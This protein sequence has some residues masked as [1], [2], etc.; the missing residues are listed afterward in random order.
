M[1]ASGAGRGARGAGSRP[2][3]SAP[4][5][6]CFDFFLTLGFVAASGFDEVAPRPQATT[7]ARHGELGANTPAKRVSANLEGGINAASR[8]RNC[9]HEREHVNASTQGMSTSLV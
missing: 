9:T 7:S 8:A 4:L 2:T 5:C 6:F 1:P 3:V